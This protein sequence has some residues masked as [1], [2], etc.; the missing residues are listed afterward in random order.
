MKTPFMTVVITSFNG[1]A[2]IGRT[3]ESL[4]A[5]NYPS[6]KLE[7][8]VV[9]DGSTDATAAVSRTYPVKVIRLAKNSGISA[10]RNA[11]LK[12]AGGEVFVGIDDDCVAYPDL[13][14]QLAKGYD[15]TRPAGVGSC[16][17]DPQHVDT[18]LKRYMVA[19]G[20]GPA[21]ANPRPSAS[22]SG[23]ITSYIKSKVQHGH[24]TARRTEVAELFGAN[25][26][27]P[28]DVLRSVGG[29]DATMS[30]IEDRDLS[31][32]IKLRYPDRPFYAM[33]AAKL[34]H[35]PDCSLM[36]YLLRP[37]RRGPMN[38]KFY[39]RAAQTP[40][41]FPFPIIGLLLLVVAA[42]VHPWLVPVVA[43]LAPQAMNFWW[44][45]RAAQE[46]RATYLLFPYVELAE[47]AMVIGG[48]ARG[49]LQQWRGRYATA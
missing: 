27:F 1:A 10:A 43:L 34:I 4:L 31:R 28:V 7:I 33:P 38:L 41:I 21:P 37:Y 36:Q 39:Q 3:I 29:W 44:P 11:A 25:G 6:D 15:H 5:Q 16:L 17:A 18:L 49:Y 13:L 2:T 12:V 9:D 35:D 19:T 46:R 20:S 40:P 47:Q 32:R 48:L 30:G 14:A 23:R 8:I 22:L 45:Y 42:Y 24:P 26:S